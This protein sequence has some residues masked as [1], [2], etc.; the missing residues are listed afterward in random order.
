[1][2]T[3]KTALITGGNGN[4]GRLVAKQMYSKGINVLC[5]DLPGTELTNEKNSKNIFLGD[6]CDLDLLNNIL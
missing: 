4:L 3:F 2:G 6:I 5:L 1:M